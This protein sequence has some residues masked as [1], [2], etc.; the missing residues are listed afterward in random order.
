MGVGVGVGGW[1][2]GGGGGRERG[3]VR[4]KHKHTTH[5]HLPLEQGAEVIISEEHTQLPLLHHRV[6]LAQTVVCEL[7][8][9]GLQKLLRYQG[10]EGR[11]SVRGG[12]V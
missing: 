5:T 12:R 7:S 3:V 11:E 2:G 6:E 8:G 4:G 1:G 9:S 10:C